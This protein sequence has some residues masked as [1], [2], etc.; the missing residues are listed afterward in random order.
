[1]SKAKKGGKGSTSVMSFHQLVL[2]T[3]SSS[4]LQTQGNPTGL[5]ARFLQEADAWTLFRWRSLRFRIF[6]GST[7]TAAGTLACLGV[8]EGLPDTPAATAAT[9][10][11]LLPSVAHC[12]DDQTVWSDWIQVP[13]AVLA[14]QQPWYQTVLGSFPAVSEVPFTFCAFG[15]ATGAIQVELR[16]T[17]EFKS[18]SAAANTPLSVAC[19]QRL[20]EEREA[21]RA[22]K[23]R[24]KLVGLL[25]LA[26]PKPEL[27]TGSTNK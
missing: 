22:A 18:Q 23:E 5:A 4:V 19:V 15:T 7:H 1:M 26:P 12:G 21:L 8:Q 3:M 24:S 14:G 13:A 9:I 20:R 16:Y 27:G 6:G 2:M 25:S 17:V 11:E 10:L